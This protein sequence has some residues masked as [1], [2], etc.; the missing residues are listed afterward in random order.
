M[1]FFAMLS[2]G[3][4]RAI[5]DAVRAVSD[6][7]AVIIA[8]PIPVEDGVADLSHLREALES[9]RRGLRRGLLIV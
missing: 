3:V 9:I 5:T 1:F 8:V 7:D 2:L 6:S 4:L